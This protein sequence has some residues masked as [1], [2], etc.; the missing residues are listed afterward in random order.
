M[1]AVVPYREGWVHEFERWRKRIAEVLGRRALRIDHIG[2]TSVPGLAA[3]D[4]ID[5]QVTVA[6]L[7]DADPL[8]EAGFRAQPFLEDHRPPGASDG[9]REWQKRFFN[10]PKGERRGNV[11]VRVEGRANQRY[12]LLFRD[13]LRA[14]PSAAEAYA[15]LKLQLAKELADE[16]AYP[17]VK[18]PA[19]DLIWVAAEEWAAATGW[20]P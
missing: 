8:A 13:Y 3:K 19:C 11:H 17:D 4:V 5:I 18:D 10:F 15:R 16:A 9:V 7:R 14:H 20:K 1:I 6:R 2:S 12:A